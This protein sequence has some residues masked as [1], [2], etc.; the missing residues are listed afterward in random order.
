M[1]LLEPG[2]VIRDT[3]E[4]ERQIGEGAF[5][6]V[7]RVRH[8]FLGR[9]AMKVFKVP[10]ATGQEIERDIDEAL[11]LSRVKHPNIVELYDANVLE[12]R[13]GRHG[14]L[15]MTYMPGGTLDRYWRS[16]G[17]ALM[18]VPEV[19]ELMKQVCRGLDVAHRSEPPIIHRDIKPQNVLVGFTAD[20]VY[21]RLSDFGLA[22]SVN[23][24]T[25]LA[26]ARG[27]ISFKPPES[28]EGLDSCAADIWSV[29]TMMYVLLTDQLPVPALN[30]D[31]FQ[32]PAR[33]KRPIRPLR[34][35]NINVDAALE[36][37]VFRCLAM[38]PEDRYPA[39]GELLKDLE[40]WK[41]AAAETP[42]SVSSFH[43]SS[44]DVVGHVSPHDLRREAAEALAQAHDV[45]R[46]P[47]QLWAA[48]DLLEEALSKDPGLRETYDAQLGL[49][50]KGVMHVSTRDV[51]VPGRHPGSPGTKRGG[52]G[53]GA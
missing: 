34:V 51:L 22:K 9:Q 19:I 39:A 28:L 20:G 27:T 4:V 37:V 47:T 8:R 38:E 53:S 21:V 35:F 3:Y 10:G 14:Y 32:D 17:S 2:A 36:S 1:S 5:A 23:P 46:D 45:A 24:L 6:E 15:T 41:P 33:F 13:G 49:W 44:K 7:Y 16:F 50:R 11:L 31:E 25:R 43:R 48:A 18:P 42:A 52:D 30:E 12:A 26:S 40:K 29:G